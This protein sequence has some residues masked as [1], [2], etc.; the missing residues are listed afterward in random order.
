MAVVSDVSPW[1]TYDLKASWV[2]VFILLLLWWLSYLP[3][4]FK[5]E[6]KKEEAAVIESGDVEESS[7]WR[8]RR[9]S[10]HFRDGMLFLLTAIVIDFASVGPASTANAL[11]WIFTALWVGIGV[12]M[13]FAKWHRII[14][15]LIFLDLVLIV[16]L[17]SNSFA[18]NAAGTD[19][20]FIGIT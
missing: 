9:I 19:A 20:F 18:K 15:L 5:G 7:L 2:A 10:R 14:S 8:L 6:R 13:I 3:F 16:A 4:I 12:T 1:V 11:A 17:I